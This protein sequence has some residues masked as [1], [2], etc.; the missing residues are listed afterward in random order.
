[1]FDFFSETPTNNIRLAAVL[2]T[3]AQVKFSRAVFDTFEALTVQF[4]RHHRFS[5]R[6]NDND[7]RSSS[8]S[9]DF[10]VPVLNPRNVPALIYPAMGPLGFLRPSSNSVSLVQ[11]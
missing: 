1:M 9:I 3:G 6:S 7:Q 2:G 11:R 5:F 8:S 10:D 4:Y